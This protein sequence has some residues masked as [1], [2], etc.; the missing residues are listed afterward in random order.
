MID[1]SHL[2]IMSNVEFTKYNIGKSMALPSM[3]K[4]MCPYLYQGVLRISIK[5]YLYQGLYFF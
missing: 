2:P 4:P 1:M 5:V 3:L